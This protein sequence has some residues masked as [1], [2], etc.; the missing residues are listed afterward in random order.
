MNMQDGIM[1]CRLENSVVISKIQSF[2]LKFQKFNKRAGWNKVVQD[3]LFLK[4]N[5]VLLQDYSEDQSKL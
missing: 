4:K 1:P 2:D 5:K 3:G